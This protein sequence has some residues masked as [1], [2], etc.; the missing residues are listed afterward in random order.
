MI[1]RSL[2]IPTVYEVP[3]KREDA[4]PCSWAW[5]PPGIHAGAQEVPRTL[6]LLP[7]WA[8]KQCSPHLECLPDRHL[9]N[10]KDAPW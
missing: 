3:A 6:G 2:P 9:Y 8:E 7:S 10:P 5:I 1:N 4:A